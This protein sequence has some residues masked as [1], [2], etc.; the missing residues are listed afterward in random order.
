MV[1]GGVS[2][3]DDLMIAGGDSLMIA[4]GVSVPDD[5]MIAGGVSM[6]AG[7]ILVSGNKLLILSYNGSN[8]TST[9]VFF[10]ECCIEDISL[11]LNSFFNIK[12]FHFALLCYFEHF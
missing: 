2:V 12:I 6:V 4:G 7:N 8:N 1:A 5:L 10:T 9:S 3:P 11:S